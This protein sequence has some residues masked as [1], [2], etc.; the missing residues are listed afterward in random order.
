MSGVLTDLSPRE[1]EVLG[2]MAEGYRNADIAR[3]LHLESS[4][5]ERHI[6]NIYSKV[7]H[8][9]EDKHPRVWVVVL[10]LR[11]QA[12]MEGDHVGN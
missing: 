3:E 12:K 11:E 8:L 2:W 1:L 7:R 5:V 4:T 10:Y 6:N 9:I